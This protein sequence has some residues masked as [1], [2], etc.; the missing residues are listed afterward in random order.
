MSIPVRTQTLPPFKK[1][2]NMPKEEMYVPGHRT[3]AGC[4]L[5]IAY[6]YIPSGIYVD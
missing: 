3:C 1:L 2:R 6:R 4:G 5:P